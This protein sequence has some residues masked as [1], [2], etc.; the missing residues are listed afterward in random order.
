MKTKLLILTSLLFI[1][2]SGCKKEKTTGNL[3]LKINAP[4]V[5][6]CAGNYSNKNCEFINGAF[7]F[8]YEFFK[9][10]PAANNQY[11]SKIKAGDSNNNTTIELGELLPGYYNIFVSPKYNLKQTCLYYGSNKFGWCKYS[12]E[13]LLIIANQD[14]IITLDKME[15]Q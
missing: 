2:I 5:A 6:P 8:Y 9:E 7:S 14:Q 15:E 12:L 11:G 10:D 1:G 13:K 3:K 4:D